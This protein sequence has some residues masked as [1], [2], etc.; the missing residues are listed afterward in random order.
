MDEQTC[1]KCGEECYRDSVDVEVGIIYGPWGC[2]GCGWSDD[3]EYDRSD[4]DSPAQKHHPNYY[5]D[6][7]GDMTPKRTLKKGVARFGLDPK[8]IDE[9]FG[10]EDAPAKGE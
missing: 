9:V 1:P 7:Y 10:P 3:S 5:V 6:Q 8:V 4:G 2:P